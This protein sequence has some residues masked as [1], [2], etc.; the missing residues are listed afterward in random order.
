MIFTGKFLVVSAKQVN[1]HNRIF[2][3]HV[4]YDIPHFV[5]DI[6]PIVFENIFPKIFKVISL[7]APALSCHVATSLRDYAI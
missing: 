1:A 5:F 7:L 6:C 2:S 4:Y 3:F